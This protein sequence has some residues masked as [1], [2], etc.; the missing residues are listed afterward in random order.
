MDKVQLGDKVK[1]KVTGFIGIA[2]GKTNWLHGCTR[3]IVQPPMDKDG[4]IPESMSFDEPQLEVISVKKV[5]KGDGK[6]GGFPLNI[7]Q[8]DAKG[9]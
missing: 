2:I 9:R 4:K 7:K 1:D 6:T 8:K 5:P 3:V